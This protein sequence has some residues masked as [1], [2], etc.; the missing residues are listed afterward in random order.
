MEL[1]GLSDL[2]P[3]R[4]EIL[5]VPGHEEGVGLSR[6]GQDDGVRQSQADLAPDGDG[7]P[8]IGALTS[9]TA[10]HSK[11]RLVSSS[12]PFWDPG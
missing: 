6:R 8:A 10:K 4:A 9:I 11:N 5:G 7:P 12:S 3:G 1:A 2:W